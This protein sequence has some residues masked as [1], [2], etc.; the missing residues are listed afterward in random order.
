MSGR[1]LVVDDVEVNRRL[2]ATRLHAEYFDVLT[3]ADGAEALAV[4]ETE[5][6]DLVL[7]DVMMPGLDG[8]EVCRQLKNGPRTQ[9]IP[10]ILV[11]ALDRTSDRVRG[12]EAGADDF[13]TKPAR[14]LQLFSRVKSLLRLKLLTDELRIRADT[15]AH[16]FESPDV[17]AEIGQGGRGGRILVVDDDPTSGSRTARILGGEHDCRTMTEQPELA[18]C[19][20]TE[21]LVLSLGIQR[22][23]PLRLCSHLRAT[24]ATRRLPILVIAGA[25]DELAV[26]KALELGV[27][28]Y[29]LR[30]IDR[31]ELLARA[32][33]QIKRGRYDAGL[34][35]S[36][37]TTIELA[38]VDALTGLQ[39]RRFLDAHLPNVIERAR[40]DNRALSMLIADIDHFKSINDRF[41]HD[42]GDE[43][44]REFAR[45]AR[46]GSRASDLV[47]RLGGEEFV[48]V[49][50]DTDGEAAAQIAERLRRLMSDAPFAVS[51]GELDVTGSVGLAVFDANRDDPASLMKRADDSLYAA[52]REGRNRVAQ[53]AA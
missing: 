30:P 45:R 28:D 38:S 43:V 42:V 8:Y 31:N 46:E 15:T 3:A 1:I 5:A 50:P 17:L 26:A 36:L 2:L 9:H 4:C 22:F 12:L 13:L 52:K 44:L 40:Q 49:M 21:L 35:Q 41:G 14:D 18:D 20:N 11:T 6:V 34:R 47:C 19:E 16:L 29:L 39:N 10:V 37:R 25:A 7:L 23:D 48:V 51:A 53:L 33:T 24:E 27:S 32:R